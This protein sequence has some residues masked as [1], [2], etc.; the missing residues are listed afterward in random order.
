MVHFEF[1]F[2]GA[3]FRSN[4]ALM[5]LVVAGLFVGVGTGSRGVLRFIWAHRSRCGAVG[6]PFLQPSLLVFQELDMNCST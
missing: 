1:G 2:D 5:G 4:L 6:F 3:F